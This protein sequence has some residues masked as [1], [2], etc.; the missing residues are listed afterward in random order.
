MASILDGRQQGPVL[1]KSG[2]LLP[3]QWRAFT[4][5]YTVVGRF[6][7]FLG[8]KGRKKFIFTGSSV[9]IMMMMF[10]HR[11]TTQD[12]S[13]WGEGAT[14]RQCVQERGSL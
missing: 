8:G 14:Q 6:M 4:R 5:L 12:E 10:A 2:D 1:S 9:T 7:F 3:L 11:S 13:N